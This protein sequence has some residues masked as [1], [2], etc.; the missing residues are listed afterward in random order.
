MSKNVVEPERPQ[1]T[2]WRMSAACCIIKATRAQARARALHLHAR[3]RMLSLTHTHRH[4]HTHTHCFSSPK[5]F[6]WTCLSVTLHVHWSSCLFY[7]CWYRRSLRQTSLS[8]GW[9]FFVFRRRWFDFLFSSRCP[10]WGFWVCSVTLL[11]I[12]LFSTFFHSVVQL[13][14][15][16]KDSSLVG[17]YA[18]S[19]AK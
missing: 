16:A 12:C 13:L 7:L 11:L 1:M 15:S 6:S 5:V 9:H 4:T 3:T 2:I 10:G 8:N 19:I 14:H 17:C 18:L